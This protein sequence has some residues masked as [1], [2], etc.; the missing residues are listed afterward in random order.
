M[1]TIPAA[2]AGAVADKPA[3]LQRALSLG[4]DGV[5]SNRPDALQRILE[6]QLI[7]A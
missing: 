5:I 1:N 4:V 2:L 6:E 3:D 7:P